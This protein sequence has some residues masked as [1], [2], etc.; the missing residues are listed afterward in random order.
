MEGKKF[1]IGDLAPVFCLPDAENNP[2]CIKDLNGKWIVLYFYP[3]DNT[4]GC[5]LEAKDFSCY[6]EKFKENGATII[7][8]SPD[9]VQ[10]H[11]KFSL[12]HELSIV[13]LSDPDHS[14]MEKYGVWK[15]KKMYGRESFG[16]ERSTF[17][18]D[19]NGK[20]THIWRKVKVDGHVEDVLKKIIEKA[21]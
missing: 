21:K 2:L 6:A 7:G 9:T 16:V 11:I 20:I 1:E 12:K 14:V 17:L 19:P 4:S 13:L 8:V 18:I 15:L 10:S 3:K 5:T